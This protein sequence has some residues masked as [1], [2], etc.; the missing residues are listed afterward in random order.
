MRLTIT[1]IILMLCAVIAF[2]A[3]KKNDDVLLS[4]LQGKVQ[5]L[6]SRKKNVSTATVAGV[7]GTK[8][9]RTDIYW[10]GK[11]KKVEINEE[12]LQKFKLAMECLTGGEKIIALKHFD[13]FLK[14]FPNSPLYAEGMQAV[15]LLKSA[16]NPS[17]SVPAATLP[18]PSAPLTSANVPKPDQ[19]IPVTAAA[20]TP[21]NI[22]M[23]EKQSLNN[24]DA[25]K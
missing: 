9:D 22:S 1:I 5:K 8:N 7:K 21:A 14:E 6:T 2:G 20:P 18:S 23:P 19:I 25:K 16:Q 13:A 4:T 24:Y 3:E 10:K 17:A 15:Q 11:E 12:E